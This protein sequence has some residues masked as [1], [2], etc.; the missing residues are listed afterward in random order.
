MYLFL[1]TETHNVIDPILIQLAYKPSDKL[2]YFSALYNTGG[3]PLDFGS[4]AVHH[5]TEAEIADK[6][7]FLDSF[8][9][10]TLQ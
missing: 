5:I 6:P 2:E 9:A 3:I 4:M 8:D 1:D 10:K 7:L